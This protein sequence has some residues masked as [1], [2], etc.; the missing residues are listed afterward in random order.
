MKKRILRSLSL[1]LLSCCFLLTGCLGG[2]F[3]GDS[4]MTPPSDDIMNTVN[5]AEDTLKTANN[6]TYYYDNLID[7]NKDK[8]L[9]ASDRNCLDNCFGD[10]YMFIDPGS[11]HIYNDHFTNTNHE[12]YKLVD[13]QISFL[14]K[15]LNE[16]IGIIYIEQP[17]TPMTHLT[18]ES[19]DYVG[20]YI[21]SAPT[22]T[23]NV[24][25]IMS[26]GFVDFNL[27]G[28][29]NNAS[30]VMLEDSQFEVISTIA[31]V[32]ETTIADEVKTRFMV[33]NIYVGEGEVPINSYIF[34]FEGAIYG[35]KL[36]DQI[37]LEDGNSIFDFYD[38][39]YEGCA[40]NYNDANKW[41]ESDKDKL[42]EKLKEVI[43][44][45]VSGMSTGS[46]DNKI[47][48]IDHL[49]FTDKDK[50]NIINEI[51]NNIIGK[52][53]VEDDNS[54][55][56]ELIRYFENYE[57][58][59]DDEK[60]LKLKE[61]FL[62]GSNATTGINNYKA[63][64]I[65]IPELV[66]Q[67]TSA[68]CTYTGILGEVTETLFPQ[69][70]RLQLIVVDSRT[71]MNAVGMEESEED[72]EIDVEDLP[73]DTE[74]LELTEKLSQFVNL[75]S[76]MFLPKNVVGERTMAKK[77][78]DEWVVDKDGEQVMETFIVEGFV[79]TDVDIVLMSA[80]NKTSI[81]TGAYT[82]NTETKQITNN[83]DPITAF[84]EKPD[85]TNEDTY[86]S[87]SMI[88]IEKQELVSEKEE[89]V[90]DYRIKGYNGCTINSEGQVI[91]NDGTQVGFATKE[92]M[93]GYN[94]FTF[95]T[96]MHN[97][98]RADSAMS[99]YG[100]SLNLQNFAGNNYV[101]VDF[102]VEEVDGDKNNRNIGLNILYL[103]CETI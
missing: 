15:S 54:Y 64:S 37:I 55:V 83:S 10:A 27:D 102:G 5:G 85:P 31:G 70:P 13:R 39:D 71:L 48:S 45:A 84:G 63:Y 22:I 3:S 89:V 60:K 41:K 28:I 2:S 12:F 51:Y 35:G 9:D 81:I 91:K 80:D 103:S 62:N 21:T 29:L 19:S 68:T 74:S 24:V 57:S 40:D 88:D 93:G 16:M 8:G 67:A 23:V 34:D 42:E 82:L 7:L 49:G 95:S 26:Q 79:L 46:Y 25:Q 100:Y 61:N 20:Q 92:T 11:N 59:T 44:T 65:I 96:N 53:N 38:D 101:L 32:A 73:T 99:E 76:I 56:D 18:Q 78:N 75:K 77:E 87:T 69:F 86:N 43:A 47:K 6:V 72:E 14:A 98:F 17:D 94:T 50:V 66:K 1:I 4:E 58:L 97:Y 90:K 33:D 36:F 52:S 30:E